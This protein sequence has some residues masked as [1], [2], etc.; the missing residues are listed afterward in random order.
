VE[1]AVRHGGG[2]AATDLGPNL[3]RAAFHEDRGPLADHSIPTAERQAISSLFAGAIGA[4]KNPGS[5][6]EVGLDD[7]TRAAELLML[8]SHLLNVVD[9]RVVASTAVSST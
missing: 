2:F 9:H 1:I 8:A 5:H 4:F 7:P 3:M 6:R